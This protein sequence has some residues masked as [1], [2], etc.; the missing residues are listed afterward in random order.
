MGHFEK[1]E[2]YEKF[3]L[4]DIRIPMQYGHLSHRP[5]KCRL[6][7]S[8]GSLGHEPFVLEEYIRIDNSERRL[9]RLYVRRSWHGN[10]D[11]QINPAGKIRQNFKRTSLNKIPQ[12][13]FSKIYKNKT[14]RTSANHHTHILSGGLCPEAPTPSLTENI[15]Q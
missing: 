3:P 10:R 6:L 1:S 5:Y 7:G 9:Q 2:R 15:T 8:I 4:I 11:G 14:P 13:I 12:E